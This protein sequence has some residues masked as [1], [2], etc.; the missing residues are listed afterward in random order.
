MHGATEHLEQPHRVEL[1]WNGQSLGVFDLLGRTRHTITVSL[2]GVPAALEN[3]LVVQHH[4]A[5]DAPPVLYVD[6]VE[7]DY[8]RGAETAENVHRLPK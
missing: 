4:V 6:A 5:G 8:I 2:S 1:L 3:E 7:V